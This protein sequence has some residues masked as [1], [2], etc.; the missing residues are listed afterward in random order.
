MSRGGAGRRTYGQAL[1][2]EYHAYYQ[3]H[4]ARRPGADPARWRAVDD[5]RDAQE[6]RWRKSDWRAKQREIARDAARDA[7]A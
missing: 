6:Q 7:A 4:P 5:L 2:A 3:H 1:L